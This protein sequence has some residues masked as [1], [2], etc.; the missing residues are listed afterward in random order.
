ML[1]PVWLPNV[2]DKDIEKIIEL[3]KD[4]KLKVG[5]QNYETYKYSRKMREV[6]KQPY[7]KFY[8]QIK[9]WEKE[10]GLPLE[11]TA[12]ELAIHKAV[13]VQEVFKKGERVQL[14]IKTKGWFTDQMIAVG[15]GRC[16]SVQHCE[17]KEGDLVNVKI[18]E[19]KN[20]I[21]LAE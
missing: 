10:L 13:R 15:R 8:D 5:L 18:L 4:L 21:Y 17:K 6:K 1:T 11:I 7:W 2:N 9:K 3:C 20:N 14:V 19:A 16:V 12:K